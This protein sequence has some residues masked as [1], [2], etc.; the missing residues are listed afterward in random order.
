MPTKYPTTVATIH[1]KEK[2]KLEERSDLS[3]NHVNNSKIFSTDDL[4]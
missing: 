3:L 4:R 2:A 1:S